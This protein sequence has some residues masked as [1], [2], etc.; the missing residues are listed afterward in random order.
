[1]SEIL[2]IFNVR[3]GRGYWLILDCGHWYKW[4]GA[5]PTLG[6]DLPCPDCAPLP[7]PV[8]IVAKQE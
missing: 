2:A 1:M 4:E 6:Q 5:R 8:P 3:P 7:V